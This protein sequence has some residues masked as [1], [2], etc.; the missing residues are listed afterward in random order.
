MLLFWIRRKLTDMTGYNA[1]AVTWQGADYVQALAVKLLLRR[2]LAA[3]IAED[4]TLKAVVMQ[5]LLPALGRTA[6][7]LGGHLGECA[8]QAMWEQCR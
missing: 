1:G 3:T 5:S 8:L 4:T 2:A 7:S 6:S